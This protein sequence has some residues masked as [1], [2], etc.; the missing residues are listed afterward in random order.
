V[1]GNSWPDVP[2]NCFKVKGREG[3]RQEGKGRIM[4]G[5]TKKWGLKEGKE[6][7]V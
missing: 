3:G 4:I 2:P 5:Q 1:S 6:I 7:K